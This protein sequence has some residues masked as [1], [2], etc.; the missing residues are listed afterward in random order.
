MDW[1]EAISENFMDSGGRPLKILEKVRSRYPVALHGTSLSI[2][3]AD[4]LRPEYL[5]RLKALVDRIDPFIV[6][7]HLCWTSVEGEELHDLLPLPMT[8]EAVKHVADR[9]KQVQDLLGRKILLEN[10]STYVTY[11]HSSMPEWEFLTEIAKRSGCGILLDLN[12]VFV[13]AFNHKFDAKEYLR[14]IPADKVGQFHL[15]GHTD[16]GKFLFD[17]HTGNVIDPVWDLYR[18]ALRLYGKVPTLIEWDADVPEWNILSAEASRAREIYNEIKTLYPEPETCRLILT[19]ETKA[20]SSSSVGDFQKR[21]KSWIQPEKQK[22]DCELNPQAGDPGAERLSVYSDG[23]LSRIHDAL[24]EAYETINK[25]IG[26]S[27]FHAMTQAYAARY[28]SKHYNLSRA[29]EN[30]PVFL[31][32]YE[33]LNEWPFLPQLAEF[34]WKVTA[35]FHAFDQKPFDMS[36]LADITVEDWER[37]VMTFQPSMQLMKSDWPLLDIW[38]ARKKPVEEIKI[39]M[40]GRPQSILIFRRDTELHMR[41]LQPAEYQLLGEIQKGVPLGEAIEKIAL[42][43]EESHLIQEWFQFWAAAGLIM[44]CEIPGR[45]VLK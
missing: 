41:L 10:V 45:P 27:R 3:S 33:P 13:N 25:V 42:A 19:S 30:L 36:A 14:N 24:L 4:P 20:G 40:I 44:R 17:T 1:F 6:S 34:E 2:G 39:D 12:N 37:S 43:E 38:S 5:K 35:A 15:A 22:L 21:M 8:E 26:H 28:A 23:Y 32:S 16:M 7:D 29:G 11:K 9:V 18:E 31:K